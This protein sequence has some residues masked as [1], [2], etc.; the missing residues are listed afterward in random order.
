MGKK[1]S[2]AV[3]ATLQQTCVIT[4][5]PI[6]IILSLSSTCSTCSLTLFQQSFLSPDLRLSLSVNYNGYDCSLH[7]AR[8]TNTRTNRRPTPRPGRAHTC[9]RRF[10]FPAETPVYNG[11]D[12]TLFLRLTP[13]LT[14]F[15]V[16]FILF[17]FISYLFFILFLF[18][19]NSIVVFQ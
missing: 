9:S 11:N 4:G 3:T 16:F 1:G 7:H 18:H 14:F 5:A 15:F 10:T 17:S 2:K 12:P 19:T 8:N 6:S 13:P